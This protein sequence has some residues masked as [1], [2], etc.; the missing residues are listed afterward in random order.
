MGFYLSLKRRK[1]RRKRRRKIKYHK[2]VINVD[3]FEA[4]MELGFNPDGSP[5]EV[6]ITKLKI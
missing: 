6:D 1:K 3:T 5:K 2:K 4:Q